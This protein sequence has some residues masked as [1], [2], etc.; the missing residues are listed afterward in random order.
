V[1]D[2]TAGTISKALQYRIQKPVTSSD[3]VLFA[4]PRIGILVDKEPQLL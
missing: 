3:Q 2:V 1:V 4:A